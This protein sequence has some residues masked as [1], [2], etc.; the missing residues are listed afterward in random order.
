MFMDKEENGYILHYLCCIAW[1][2][3][4]GNATLFTLKMPGITAALV[5]VLQVAHYDIDSL[6]RLLTHPIP[7]EHF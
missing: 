7:D 1:Q 5:E 4:V 2:Q 3:S 6:N